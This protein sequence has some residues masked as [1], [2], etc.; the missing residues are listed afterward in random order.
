MNVPQIAFDE[1]PEGPR[2]GLDRAIDFVNTTGLSKGKPFDDLPTAAAA[3]GWLADAGYLSAE[4]AEAERHR[5]QSSPARAEQAL[6]RLRATRAG[7]RELID[8]NAENRPPR[9]A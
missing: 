8:A 7:L 3:I 1:P 9:D 4:A 6:R 2:P 5:V